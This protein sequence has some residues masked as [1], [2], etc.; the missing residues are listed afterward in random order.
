MMALHKY[1]TVCEKEAPNFTTTM[2]VNDVF[3][4][5]ISN[6]GHTTDS[7]QFEIPM[8]TLFEASK[9]KQGCA[10]LLVQKEGVGRLYYRLSLSYTPKNLRVEATGNG[11]T[12]NRTYQK[13]SDKTLLNFFTK[14]GSCTVKKGE[15][16]LVKLHMQ[17]EHRQYNVVLV[18][19][20]PA[21][22]EVENPALKN[23]QVPPTG[24]GNAKNWF[25]HENIR[26]ERVEWFASV[27]ESGYYAA[28]YTARATTG[29]DFYIPPATV[30]DMYFADMCGRTDSARITIQ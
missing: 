18:D 7:F 27:L 13:L 6:K 20:L 14:E 24:S 11:F 2:W 19:K 3:S 29:G 5:E 28:E 25:E 22:F 26:D 8:G 17:V 4:G 15:L 12:L 1:F 10:E 9:L 21:G 30:E 16:I 23:V